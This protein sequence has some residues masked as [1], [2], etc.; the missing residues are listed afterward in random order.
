M[1][2]LLTP[3][4]LWPAADQA[5]QGASGHSV[6]VS[7]DFMSLPGIMLCFINESSSTASSGEGTASRALYVENPDHTLLRSHLSDGVTDS[8]LLSHSPWQTEAGQPGGC[9]SQ[10]RFPYLEP[11]LVDLAAL[12]LLLGGFTALLVQEGQN[13]CGTEL[14]ETAQ[15]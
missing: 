9:A 8:S 1:T 6:T 15:R 3:A 14:E 2:P 7:M 13:P 11:A 12:T 5:T 4:Q 10:F